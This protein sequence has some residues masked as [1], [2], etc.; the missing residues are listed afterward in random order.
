MEEW[1]EGAK[2][3]RRAERKREEWRGCTAQGHDL[4]QH[5]APWRGWG[6]QGGGMRR[7]TREEEDDGV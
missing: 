5:R 3:G 1:G 4:P 7:G 2:E 6:G